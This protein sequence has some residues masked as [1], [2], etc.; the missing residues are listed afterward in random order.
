MYNEKKELDELQIESK[1]L[2]IKTEA[3][4]NSIVEKLENQNFGDEIRHTL[5]NPIIIT[6]FQLFKMKL[7]NFK[8]RLL[9]VL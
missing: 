7:K 4:K 8:D 9:D 5:R 1:V 2:E 3:Y 6:K